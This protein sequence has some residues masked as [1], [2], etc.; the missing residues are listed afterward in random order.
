MS[1]K[2]A[3]HLRQG[4][5]SAAWQRQFLTYHPVIGWWFIPHLNAMIVHGDDFYLLR[6]NSVG[7][8]SDREYPLVRPA[9]RY[10]IAVLGDSFTAGDGVKNTD[11]FSDLLEES[12]PNLDVLNF[13][14][15]GSGTDQQLLVYESLAKPFEVDAYVF[16]IYVLN[17]LRNQADMLATQVGDEFW[18]RPKPYF[19]LDRD[20]LV[21]HNE[22]V[23][24]ERISEEE[25]LKGVVSFTLDETS[26]VR[27]LTLRIVPQWMRE[28]GLFQRI[29]LALRRP[30]RDYDSEESLSWQLMRRIIQR[31]TQQVHGKPV[32]ILPLPTH[33]HIM[34]GLAPTYLARFETLH[35]PSNLRFAVDVLPY[36][37][38]LSNQRLKECFLPN[39]GHFSPLGHKV[40]AEAISD[41]LAKHCPN[42]LNWAGVRG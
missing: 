29:S 25:A 36:F 5:R 6:T 10:R 24:S 42:I 35:E 28:M 13:G 26:P 17:I 12:Y 21:L 39:D 7:M 11:R 22:P 41:I 14:L 20:S 27:V 33:H 32:F 37:R 9:G 23:P 3:A 1:F 2:H 31:F 18:Y 40:M 19:T 16:V 4:R 15:P 34:R 8:R 38:R 30:Y